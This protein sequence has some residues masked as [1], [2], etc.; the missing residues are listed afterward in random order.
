MFNF[1]NTKKQGD[2]GLGMAI[3]WAAKK[4]YTVSLPLTDSQDYDIIFDDDVKLY[5]TQVKTTSYKNEYDSY[6]VSLTIKGGN[7][8]GTG[9]I[10]KLDKSKVDALFILTDNWEIYFIPIEFVKG[11]SSISL[12]ENSYSSFKEK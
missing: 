2:V 11:N 8:S 6:E 5:R 3:S 9:K 7:K 4:G 10:K 12:G 1:K